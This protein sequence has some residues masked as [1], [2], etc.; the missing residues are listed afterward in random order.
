[1]T[2]PRRNLPDFESPPLTEVLISVQFD[3]L[4]GLQV[5]QIGLFWSKIRDRFPHTEQ[6]AP[7]DPVNERF[8][9]PAPPQIQVAL[10]Q[11]PPMLR[12]WFLNDDGSE[13]IQIQADRF[14]HNWRKV[15]IQD[16]YPRY[17]YVRSQFVRGISEFCGF[18][19]E[20]E[21]GSIRPT[22]CE[23]SYI[24]HIEPN[25][26]WKSH[27]RIGEVISAWNP[28][29]LEEASPDI[30]SVGIVMQQLIID[31]GSKPVGRLHISA[32]PAYRTNSREPLIV[33][34]LTARGAPAEPTIEGI[35]EFADR[36]RDEIVRGFASVTTPTMHKYWRR[37]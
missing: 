17:E 2:S 23:V 25:E 16:A 18:L 21:I 28:S 1:M 7:V 14:M 24:N 4:P 11:L 37:T 36:G 12:T 20:E 27:S 22:Q 19:E 26:I 33:L 9:P 5:P 34:S 8:G 6:H 32:Q 31:E 29:K 10:S 13:L 3:P 30:E 35:L 15:E